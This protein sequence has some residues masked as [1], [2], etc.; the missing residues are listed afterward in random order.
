MS[1]QNYF[2]RTVRKA[3]YNCVQGAGQH[4]ILNGRKANEQ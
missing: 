1:F 2:K 4:E 3:D